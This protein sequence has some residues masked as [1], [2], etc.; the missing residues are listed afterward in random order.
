EMIVEDHLRECIACRKVQHM[1]LSQIPAKWAQSGSPVVHGNF[2]DVRR[3]AIAAML[4][5]TV[6]VSIV[7]ANYFYAPLPGNRATVQAVTGPV[8]LIASNSQQP[9]LPGRELN[10][11]D[12]IRTGYGSHAV[13]KLFDGSVVEV[14]ERA[15]FSVT[16]RRRATTIHLGRG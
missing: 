9:L 5:F 6:G 2:W 14:N 8:Y 3:M 11:G 12:V 1:E 13:V 16:A 15:E 7:L 10:E 4:L